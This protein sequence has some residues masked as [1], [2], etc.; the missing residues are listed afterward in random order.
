MGLKV[1]PKV[2]QEMGPKVGQEMDEAQCA[3]S[4]SFS[5]VEVFRRR[6][7]RALHQRGFHMILH[8]LR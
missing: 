7:F 8:H 5:P 1:G 2:S 4:K 6:I 3:S